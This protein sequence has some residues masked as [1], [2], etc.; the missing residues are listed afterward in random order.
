[1]LSFEFLGSA[2]K[3]PT[4]AQLEAKKREL[5]KQMKQDPFMSMYQIK[6]KQGGQD[7]APGGGI[8][9]IHEVPAEDAVID[10]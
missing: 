4:L 7:A 9:T 6:G 8:H 3:A 10:T 1:V 2:P 5:Q